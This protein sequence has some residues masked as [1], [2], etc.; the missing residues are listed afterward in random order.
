MPTFAT[1]EPISLTLNIAVG[2][3]DVTATDRD[4]TVVNVRPSDP[5]SD[6]DV[7]AAEQTRVERTADGVLVKGPKQRNFVLSP[8]IGS[9]DVTIEL[10]T[11]SRVQ[12]ETGVGGFRCLGRVGECRVKA[13]VG[14]VQLDETGAL[15]VDT[16]A[17]SVMVQRV[18]GNAEVS[19]GSG[20]IR[21]HRVDGSAVLKNSNGDN[22]VDE[23]GGDV[24][25]TTAN[26]SVTVNRAG[27]GV[28]AKS[29]NGD[30]RV[31]DITR[32]EASLKTALG[33]I[34]VGIHS[35]TAARLDVSTDFGRVHNNMDTA[36]GP[37]TTDETANVHAHTSFGDIVIRRAVNS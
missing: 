21:V 30:V 25:A 34:E 20:G 37:A 3:T 17:G 8:K 1:P 12:A 33:Q 13:G 18:A 11:G 15:D 22:W 36:D 32:G 9:I 29:A 5:S 16:G 6:A 35:G 31:G 19:T 10:P 2:E 24:R 26:G 14:D 4:D 28:T 27:A 7:H 23:V